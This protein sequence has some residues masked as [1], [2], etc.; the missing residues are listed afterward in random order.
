MFK[1][2]QKR[3][4]ALKPFIEHC[5]QNN[6]FKCKSLPNYRYIFISLLGLQ[7]CWKFCTNYDLNNCILLLP[8]KREWLYNRTKHDKNVLYLFDLYS[9]KEFISFIK[10]KDMQTLC[11]F[12]LDNSVGDSKWSDISELISALY[13]PRTKTNYNALKLH[14]EYWYNHPNMF[15]ILHEISNVKCNY[16]SIKTIIKASNNDL[17]VIATKSDFLNASKKKIRYIAVPDRNL[18]NSHWI[19]SDEYFNSE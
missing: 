9:D 17:K 7:K 1:T 14:N 6:G 10:Y 16:N 2:F 19:I 13:N 15:G 3:N 12:M 18:P 8:I 4:L 11:I 5:K